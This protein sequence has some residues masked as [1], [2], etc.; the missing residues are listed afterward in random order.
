MAKVNQEFVERLNNAIQLSLK[1]I[2]LSIIA[3]AETAGV[4]TSALKKALKAQGLSRDTQELQKQKLEKAIELYVK[5]L[6]ITEASTQ[7]AISNAT[8]GKALSARGLLRRD[9]KARK[10]NLQKA[11]EYYQQGLSV[12]AAAKKAYVG[13][14]TLVAALSK[15]GL[16][17]EQ[18]SAL[19]VVTDVYQPEIKES[20]GYSK[21]LQLLHRS[22]RNN[23][24]AFR[25]MY[26]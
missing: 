11:I 5:G 17:R 22:A 4:S 3:C 6:T 18:D 25:G 8:L 19:E 7:V 9:V 23:L 21:A 24:V 26:V 14:S 20:R 15:Q 10:I 1:N 16:L 13:H 12:N 2:N